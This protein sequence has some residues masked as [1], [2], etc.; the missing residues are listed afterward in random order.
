MAFNLPSE[1]AP[2]TCRSAEPH[3]DNV[4]DPVSHYFN[5][6]EICERKNFFNVE[7]EIWKKAKESEGDDSGAEE[8]VRK[9]M[10]RTAACIEAEYH[11]TDILRKAIEDESTRASERSENIRVLNKKKTNLV[12]VVKESL[13]EWRASADYK[14]GIKKIQEWPGRSKK[15]GQPVDNASEAATLPI[16]G[17]RCT[18]KSE[19]AKPAETR[20]RISP[21]RMA[22]RRQMS[23]YAGIKGSNHNS[24]GQQETSSRVSRKLETIEIPEYCVER[25]VNA[26]IIQYRIPGAPDNGEKYDKDGESTT[27]EDNGPSDTSRSRHSRSDVPSISESGRMDLVPVEEDKESDWR[28]K[29]AFP[30]QRIPMTY[31]LQDSAEHPEDSNILSKNRNTDRVRHI[32]IPSNNMQVG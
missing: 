20:Q 7:N 32:H 21:E 2:I 13:K 30:D 24:S 26:H 22:V 17:N 5:C 29:K 1:E 18:E 28:F 10:S 6:I 4:Q 19:A 23:D 9:T 11:R 8:R 31:L 12:Q 27:L 3:D 25:D 16:N 15:R 14:S